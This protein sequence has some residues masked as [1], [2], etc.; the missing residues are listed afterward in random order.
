MSRWKAA[1][2][3]V[4]VV[5]SVGLLAQPATAEDPNRHGEPEDAASLDYTRPAV[6]DRD[7]LVT[8]DME[9]QTPAVAPGVTCS[10]ENVITGPNSEPSAPHFQLLY[11]VPLDQTA[12]SVLDVP[13]SC[14]DGTVL[15]SAV[16]RAAWNLSTWQARRNAG[17][18]YRTLNGLYQH[19][20]TGANYSTRS[21]R[22][23]RSD[24]YRWEWDTTS[25]KAYDNSSPRLDMLAAELDANGYDVPK[26]RYAILMHAD[27]QLHGDCGYTI[28]A[29]YIAGKYGFSTR[30][31]PNCQSYGGPKTPIR[32]GCAATN[33][34]AFLAHEMTHMVGASAGH[35][36]DHQY[37]LMVPSK[38]S[39]NFNTSPYLLWDH[40]R[41]DYHD[42]VYNSVYVVKSNLPGNYF[43]C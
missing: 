42:T 35:V 9:A 20:F 1:V 17:L 38:G 34:D 39:A 6:G 26:T 30:E 4:T 5:L 24:Y 11:F 31:L 8:D 19:N 7:A 25:I 37:D 27:A 18:N 10:P 41:N 15:H 28:G 40:N 21:V 13:R 43:T 14:S 12:A 36:W 22:R 2:A 29:A 32:Y 3:I 23:Y 33:G 16:A